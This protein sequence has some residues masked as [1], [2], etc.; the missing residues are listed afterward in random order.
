MKKI[1]FLSLFFTGL[2]QAQVNTFYDIQYDSIADVDPNLLSLDVY[3][4]VGNELRP[5]AIYIH[6]GGWCIGDKSNVHEK[7]KMLNDLGYVF[8][9]VNYSLSPF[10]YELDN[11][12]RIKYPDHPNDIVKAI[13][14]ILDNAEVYNGDIENVFLFGHSAGAHLAATVLTDQSLWQDS[15]YSPKDIKCACILDTAGFDLDTW[16]TES[17]TDGNLFINAFTN[18]PMVW[19]QASPLFQIDQNEDLPDMLLVYQSNI[20]RILAN[21]EFADAIRNSTSTE[22]SEI[23]TDYDHQ[24][25]NQLLGDTSSEGSEAY[26][27]SFLEWF[28]PCMSK[29]TS[30]QTN[31]IEKEKLVR[32]TLVS[33]YLELTTDQDV[34]LYDYSGRIVLSVEGKHGRMISMSHLPEGV[35]IVA[36]MNRENSQIIVKR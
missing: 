20:K 11:P 16:I 35:Y 21:E 23:S 30:T 26:T 36:T 18:D 22:V 4:P 33:D 13:S 14:Y 1:I 17:A 12:E 29:V 25:I 28:V 2:L 31:V 24:Q 7:A 6:G 8:I 5:V 32:S 15:N 3:K 27:E 10:P 34:I 19:Q 9:S